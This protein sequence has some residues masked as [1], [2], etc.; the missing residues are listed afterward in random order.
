MREF[1]NSSMRCAIK[2]VAEGRA[3]G[4]ISAGNTGAH[5]ALAKII[6]KTMPGID[7]PALASGQPRL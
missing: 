6:L 1:P 2:A 7:R 5:M 3:Q 4:V